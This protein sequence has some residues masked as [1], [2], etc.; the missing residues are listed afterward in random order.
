MYPRQLNNSLTTRKLIKQIV[1]NREVHL[2]FIN[3]YLHSE[4]SL[5]KSLNNFLENFNYRQDQIELIEELSSH[6]SEEAG[7]V[8]WLTDLLVDLGQDI[9]TPSGLN[10]T[11]EYFFLDNEKNTS[12]PETEK[13]DRMISALVSLNIAEKRSCQVLSAYLNALKGLPETKEIMKIREVF[14]NIWHEEVGHISVSTRLVAKLA[15]KSPYHSQKVE[16]TKQKYMAIDFAAYKNTFDIMPGV[17][18]RRLFNLFTIAQHVPF[19]DSV[20]YLTQRLP[21][22]L[23]SPKVHNTRMQVIEKLWDEDFRSFIKDYTVMFVNSLNDSA[24]AKFKV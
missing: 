16:Q 21:E 8:M 18:I 13:D 15:K 11:D 2:M 3:S 19:W 14:E 5:Y 23:F 12:S 20:S 17:E 22:T 24:S 6:T 7:H 4:Q 1:S 10:F 9:C